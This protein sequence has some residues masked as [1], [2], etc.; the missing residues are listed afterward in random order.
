MVPRRALRLE[1]V[2]LPE[3]LQSSTK[4]KA[5]LIDWNA[6]LERY[7]I[8]VTIPG[9]GGAEVLKDNERPSIEVIDSAPLQLHSV[10]DEQC[11]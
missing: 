1:L 3:D 4:N 7:M 2:G 10:L 11:A 5:D 6:F 8:E 9:G